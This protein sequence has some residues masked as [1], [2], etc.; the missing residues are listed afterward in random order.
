MKFIQNTEIIFPLCIKLGLSQ[1]S[2]P[3][4]TNNVMIKILTLFVFVSW[5]THE[6]VV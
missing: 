2:Q 3:T 4:N 5:L 6:G 1:E